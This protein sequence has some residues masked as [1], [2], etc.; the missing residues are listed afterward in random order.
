MRPQGARQLYQ[1][2]RGNKMPPKQK[3]G[4]EGG[5]KGRLT[6]LTSVIC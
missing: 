6:V 4:R 1:E 2:Q 5:R 3:V